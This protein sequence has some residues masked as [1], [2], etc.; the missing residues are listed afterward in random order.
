MIDLTRGRQKV[1]KGLGGLKEF[2]IFPYDNDAVLTIEGTTLIN[3]SIPQTLYRFRNANPTFG[4]ANPIRLAI[5][6]HESK[7]RIP[8]N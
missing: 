7:F 2:Y 4:N 6:G 8:K 5:M 3:I 1:C